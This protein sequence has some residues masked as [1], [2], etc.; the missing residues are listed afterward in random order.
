MGLGLSAEPF[1]YRIG[2]PDRMIRLDVFLLQSSLGSSYPRLI[3]LRNEHKF[4][5]LIAL[6]IRRNTKIMDD[7]AETAQPN[8]EVSYHNNTIYIYKW[9]VHLRPISKPMAQLLQQPQTS[10]RP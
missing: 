6:L 10:R 1:R 7:N 4:P 9:R 2:V 8:Y 3:I 5:D